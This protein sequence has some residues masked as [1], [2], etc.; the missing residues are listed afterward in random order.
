MIRMTTNAFASTVAAS[1]SNCVASSAVTRVTSHNRFEMLGLFCTQYHSLVAPATVAF[2]GLVFTPSVFPDLISCTRLTVTRLNGA[3]RAQ[4]GL[5]S[6]HRLRRINY[7]RTTRSPEQ[8]KNIAGVML[9]FSELR[10]FAHEM[11]ACYC[12]IV[13]HS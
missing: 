3:L 10:G 12:S 5:N 9:S 7:S 1:T 8:R 6:A 4:S 11:L 13:T 2:R